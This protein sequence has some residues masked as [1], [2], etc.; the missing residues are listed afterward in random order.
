MLSCVAFGLIT[1]SVLAIGLTIWSLRS[2]AIQ[3]ADNDTGNIAAVLSEQIARS[4]QSVDIVLT[5]VCEQTKTLVPLQQNEFDEQIRSRDFYE[6]L[7]ERLNRLSQ[8][9]F[10][11]II[12]KEGEVAVTTE[13][14]P[15]PK[16]NVADRDYFQH[17]KSENDNGI[18]ISD[19]LTSRITRARIIFFGKRL[20]GANNDFLGVVLIGLRLSYFESIYNSITSLRNQSLSYARKLVTA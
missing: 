16:T 4:I 3:D 11:S 17:F 7:R 19:L 5:D 8:A 13:Q 18:Y 20:S 2:D 6:V 15:A 14:W 12:D 10:I 1:L 9:E